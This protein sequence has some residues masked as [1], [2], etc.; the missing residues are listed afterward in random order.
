VDK[1]L[2]DEVA[3]IEEAQGALRESIEETKAL[4][5]QVEKL[6]KRHKKSL[7]KSQHVAD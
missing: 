2:V 4:A 1:K 7:Q 5:D 6:L 3:K